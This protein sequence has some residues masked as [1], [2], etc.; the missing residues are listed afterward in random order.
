M[1]HFGL[2][3][4]GA[5]G[6]VHAK[7]ILANPR[8]TLTSVYDP[9][10]TRAKAIADLCGA[11]LA[12]G[13]DDLL[14]QSLEAVLIASA[15]TAHTEQITRS[16]EAGKAVLCEKPIHNDLKNAWPAVRTTPRRAG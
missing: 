11:H 12:T 4:A 9:D 3:G 16:A 2:F 6:S 15:T 10:E 14:S 7:N 13:V 8:T 1:V 5:I